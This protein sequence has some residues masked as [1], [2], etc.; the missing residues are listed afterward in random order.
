MDLDSPWPALAVGL[1]LVLTP[2]PLFVA[3]KVKYRSI[4]NLEIALR[5][6]SWWRT[7]RNILFTPGHWIE[8]VRAYFGMR[9][10][11][12]A[13]ELM[14]KAGT[15]PEFSST[16]MVEGIALVVATLAVCLMVGAFRIAEGALAPVAFVAAAV[17]AVVPVEVAG[18]AL[19]LAS[20][21]M[22]ALKSLPAFFATLALGLA[23]LGLLFGQ[24]MTAVAFGAGFAAAPLVV[25]FSMHRELVI[26][27]LQSHS[28]RSVT[29]R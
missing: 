28:T 10:L 22:I 24:A 15:Y 4:E 23:A 13:L 12:N 9:C 16:W 14:R 1:L 20:S 17:F 21:T 6:S 5:N 25:A 18:L 7:W 29:F 2:V 3:G 27:V 19:I 26:P 11:L 8:L